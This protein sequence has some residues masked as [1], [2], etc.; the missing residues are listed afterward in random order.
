MVGSFCFAM[1]SVWACGSDSAPAD[2]CPKD[3]PTTE[4]DESECRAVATLSAGNEAVNKRQCTACHGP[5][6]AGKTD[7]LT[8]KPEYEKNLQGLPVK[9]YPP[10]LTND[11]ETGIGKWADE[12]LVVAIREGFDKESLQLCP[13]M[14]HYKNMSDFEAYSIVMYLRSLPVVSTQIPRSVCPPTKVQE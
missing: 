11:P 14:Q 5:D 4:V 12:E 7:P 1:A 6:M 8:G 13:Q 2:A 9:L 3:D 10:N